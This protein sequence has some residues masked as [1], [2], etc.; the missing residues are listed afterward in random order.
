MSL[1]L[2]G[3]G[4]LV[5]GASSGI[6]HA[7]ARVLAR[8]V[9]PSLKSSTLAAQPSQLRSTSPIGQAPKLPFSR[10]SLSS[11]AW[12]P[13]QQRGSDDHRPGCLEHIT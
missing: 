5:T 10:T 9:P 1:K 2:K 4:A 8:L 12:N 13:H 3:T 7:T 6:G 11:V